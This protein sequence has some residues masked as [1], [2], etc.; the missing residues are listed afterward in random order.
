MSEGVVC[1][2]HQGDEGDV[3]A[4]RALAKRHSLE[5]MTRQQLELVRILPPPSESVRR[6]TTHTTEADACVRAAMSTSATVW[7]RRLRSRPELS[8][9]WAMRCQGPYL[10]SSLRSDGE[11]Q[12]GLCS[13]VEV[14]QR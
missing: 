1:E 10:P 5:A 11:E 6:H 13:K 3:G 8:R 12:A 4:E 2:G 9:C 14:A 7:T